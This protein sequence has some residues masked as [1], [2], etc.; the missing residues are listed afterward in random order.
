MCVC[1]CV[2]VCVCAHQSLE[3]MIYKRLPLF[4]LESKLKFSFVSFSYKFNCLDFCY[5]LN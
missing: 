5:Y 1:V 4:Q 2:C 3:K